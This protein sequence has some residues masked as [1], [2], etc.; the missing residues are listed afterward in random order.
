MDRYGNKPIAIAIAI[1]GPIILG[2]VI[3][4]KTIC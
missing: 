1:L 2:L 3:Y 4:A